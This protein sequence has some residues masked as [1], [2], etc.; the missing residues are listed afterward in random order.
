MDNRLIHAI[1]FGA[2]IVPVFYLV[3]DIM[4]KLMQFN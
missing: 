3:F 1:G 2:G 4:I